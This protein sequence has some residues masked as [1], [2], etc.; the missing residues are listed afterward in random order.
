[1]TGVR[2]VRLLGSGALLIGV[3]LQGSSVSAE[4][5]ITV[6]TGDHPGFGR[7]VIDTTGEP[8]YKIEQSG[9]RVVVRLTQPAV[10]DRA[11][12]APHNITSLRTSGAAVELTM[13]PGATLHHSVL[14]GRVVIDINDPSPQQA[15]AAGA[16]TTGAPTASAA[17]AAAPTEPKESRKRRRRQT[18]LAGMMGSPELGGRAKPIVA[19]GEPASGPV[20]TAQTASRDSVAG[21]QPA[22]P[23][24]EPTQAALGLSAQRVVAATALPVPSEASTNPAPGSGLPLHAASVQAAAAAVAVQPRGPVDLLARAARLPDGTEGTAA[25]LPFAPTTGAAAFQR[26]QDLVIIFDERRPVD[27]SLLRADPVFGKAEVRLLAA[28]TL[29][30]VPN[31]GG[32]SFSLQASQNGWRIVGSK[33]AP[34]LQPIAAIYGNGDMTLAADQPINVVTM[35]DPDTGATL[36]VGT[37]RRTGQAVVLPRRS[38]DFILRPTVLGVVVE[39]L[40]DALTMKVVTNGFQMGQP[41]RGLSISPAESGSGA[42]A[43]ALS[44]TRRL[45]LQAGTADLLLPRLISQ[46]DEAAMTP[47]QARGPKRLAAAVTMISLGMAAEAQALLRVATE[48]DPRLAASPEVA[49]LSAVAAL[50]AGR[51]SETDELNDP[52]L[53]GADDIAFWRAV[54]QAMLEDAA[55]SAAPVFASTA[56]LLSLYPKAVRDRIL[57]LI[58]E[59]LIQGGE[60]AAA[61]RLLAEYKGDPKLGYARALLTLKQGDGDKA[62]ATLDDLANGRD[63]FDRARAAVQAV[64]L[65]LAASKITPA[66]AADAMDRLVYAWRGDQRELALRQRIAELR[67]QTGEWRLALATLRQAEADFPDQAKQVHSRLQDAFA[68]MVSDPRLH[69][70]PPIDVVST[71]EE[72]ADL[73]AARHDDA[74]VQ[75]QLADRLLALDLPGRAGPVLEK[76]MKAASTPLSKALYGANLAALAVREKNDAAALAA[77]DVSEAANLPAA[78][79]ERRTLLRA[80]AVAHGGDPKAADA[81]LTALGTPAANQARAAILEQAQ[82]WAGAERAWADYT[83]KALPESGTLDDDQARALVRLATA[84]ARAGDDTALSGLREQYAGRL[85]DGA[86]ADMFRL[87]TAEPLRTTSDLQRVR[88]D[89]SLAQ[90]LPA[91]LRALYNAPS[92]PKN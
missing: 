53:S 44:L 28:G 63:Q 50:L 4:P 54:R 37:T 27:L 24:P 1:M 23:P 77:L 3:S 92:P 10:L 26:A 42:V 11:P 90:S 83:A 88:Q 18:S 65:R 72:N 52:R 7:V 38:A 25:V 5:V 16:A 17:E 22:E 62:L 91:N 75:E 78:L 34:K 12:A 76:L 41:P 48:Q 40:A 61:S 14:A 70:M 46:I 68:E 89:I 19:D 69:T 55:A 47:A 30:R 43:D 49:A 39:P 71:I 86:L 79:V 85:P 82:D 33:A 51:M 8:Q 60:L 64:E 9:S 31:P 36:L 15:A 74:R 13:A 80:E 81:L 58:A 2:T 29:V 57:P 87:L 67:E 32:L 73:A 59:T 84:A 6:R 35:A 21:T 66:Q 45:N 20:S 56:P